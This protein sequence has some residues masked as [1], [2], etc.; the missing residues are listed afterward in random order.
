MLLV[1]GFVV[2]VAV[3]VVVVIVGVVFVVV[4]VITVVQIVGVVIIVVLKLSVLVALA[5]LQAS[6]RYFTKTQSPLSCVSIV[7]F[8]GMPYRILDRVLWF[9]IY[10]GSGCNSIVGHSCGSSQFFR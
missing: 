5:V 7:R 4:V 9:Y 1:V 3:V 6:I 10:S 2:V 8:S